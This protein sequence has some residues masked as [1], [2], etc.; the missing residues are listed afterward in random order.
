MKVFF[1]FSKYLNWHFHWADEYSYTQEQTLLAGLQMYRSV[2]SHRAVR[3]FPSSAMYSKMINN[4]I[5]RL[6]LDQEVS[7]WN[8][9]LKFNGIT[10]CKSVCNLLVYRK[11][12]LSRDSP[13]WPSLQLS[14]PELKVGHWA[15]NDMPRFQTIHNACSLYLHNHYFLNLHVNLCWLFL[16]G[17]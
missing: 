11:L 8:V 3:F 9:K 2:K 12:L 10:N 14:E 4:L 15:V 6:S 13:Q 1:H 5:M 17:E 16:G 7:S